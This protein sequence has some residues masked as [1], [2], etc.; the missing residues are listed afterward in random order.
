MNLRDKTAERQFQGAFLL[1]GAVAIVGSNGLLLSPI[2]ADVG[3]S[4][5]TDVVSISQAISVYAGAT[6]G[7]AFLLAPQIDR[8]GPRRAAFFGMAAL[9][10]ALMGSA[11]SPN[12]W[13]LAGAQAI[14]GLG[15][16]IILPASYTLATMLCDSQW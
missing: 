11:S 2:L 13:T 14:A 8:I 9:V 12:W 15:A 5:A 7:S 10:A 3:R 6:A 1:M 4:Y 16:G